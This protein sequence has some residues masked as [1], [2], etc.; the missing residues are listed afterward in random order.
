MAKR[1]LGL[2]I[3]KGLREIKAHKAGQQVLQTRKFKR[4]TPKLRSTTKNH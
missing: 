2:E 3:L 1:N 4:R